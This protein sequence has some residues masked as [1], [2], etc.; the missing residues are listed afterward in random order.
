MNL[1]QPNQLDRQLCR[2]LA[3]DYLIQR[4][5]TGSEADFVEQIK[6]LLAFF[7]CGCIIGVNGHYCQLSNSVSLLFGFQEILRVKLS[8]TVELFADAV[9]RNNRFTRWAS[10]REDDAIF[11]SIGNAFNI[12]WKGMMAVA[13]PPQVDLVFNKVLEKLESDLR[14]SLPTRIV[15][16]LE[17]GKQ[18]DDVLKWDQSSVL[19]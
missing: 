11:G 10:G 3:K 15:L 13:Y 2:Q 8:L 5:E 6:K 1:I 9:H 12:S 14:T 7:G 18:L 19:C 17:E 16:V 4:G